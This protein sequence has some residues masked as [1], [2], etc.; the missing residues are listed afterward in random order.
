M[1]SLNAPR[2]APATL[3]VRL[4]RLARLTAAEVGL[5]H[6]AERDRRTF[7][8]RR[9]MIR[10]GEPI[11][12]RRALLSGWA[13]RQRILADGR[14]Q[15]LGLILPGDLI[16]VGQHRNPLAPASILAVTQLVT[17]PLPPAAP[18]SELAEAYA[19]SAAIDE[20]HSM[21]QITRL[22]RLSAYERLVD[23]L[24]EIQ[25]RLLLVDQAA[26]RRFALPLTQEYLADTLGLT[27]VHVNRTLQAMRRDNA[28]VLQA[29]TI[30][31]PDRPRLERLVGYEP[32]RVS[33]D[34]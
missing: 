10:Q 32:V 5:L 34:G 13:C 6:T 19:R 28:I 15:I 31:F 2:S 22:G 7:A 23:L 16:G 4:S 30:S 25:D 11:K 18:D 8:A 17:C 33:A 20:H 1:S 9:D 24:L 21:A 12:A 14:R 3:S 27:S 29:G 26:A